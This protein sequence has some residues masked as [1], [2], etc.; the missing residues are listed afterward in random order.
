MNDQIHST[1][2]LTNSQKQLKLENV[3]KNIP[4]LPGLNELLTDRKKN[5]E[6]SE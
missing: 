4:I 1:S 5:P 3:F 2:F 6:S